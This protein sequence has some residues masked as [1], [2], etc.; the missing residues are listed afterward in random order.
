MIM[1]KRNTALLIVD[2]QKS[3]FW[4]E[5][6]LYKSDELLN[7]IQFLISKAYMVDV[8][9]FFT[10]HNGKEGTPNQKGSPGWELHPSIT[11]LTDDII[12][13]KDH[14][15]SFQQTDLQQQLVTRKI[16]RIIVTGIQSE[17]CVDATCRRAFSHGYEVIL[18]ED[19]HSTYD[20][21]ILKAHQIINHHNNIHGNW[22]ACVKKAKE[23]KF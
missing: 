10:K 9:V 20:S 22:F 12:I 15:D 16:N 6:S 14:P 13:E 1:E 5:R 11:P 17:I 18:V 4:Q 8:P 7:N 23:I 21:G 3:E 2:V 19:G